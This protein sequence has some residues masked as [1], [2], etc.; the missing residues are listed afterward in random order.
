MQYKGSSHSALGETEI[1]ASEAGERWWS[2]EPSLEG[3]VEV[4]QQK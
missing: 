2:S 3:L 4:S 1:P